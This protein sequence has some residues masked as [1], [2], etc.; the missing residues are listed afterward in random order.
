MHYAR[1]WPLR[2]RFSSRRRSTRTACPLFKNLL[3]WLVGA[4][5]FAGKPVALLS[6]SARATYAHEQAHLVLTTMS[7]LLVDAASLVIQLPSRDMSADA[8]VADAAIA[9]AL[10]ASIAALVAAIPQT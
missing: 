10:R 7:A 2:T 1:R 5:D 9:D 3:D 8:I 4:E 6:P